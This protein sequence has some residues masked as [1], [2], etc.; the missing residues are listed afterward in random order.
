MVFMLVNLCSGAGRFRFVAIIARV[1][2]DGERSRRLLTITAIF[3]VVILSILVLFLNVH[4]FAAGVA[5]EILIRFG[6]GELPTRDFDSFSTFSYIIA[7]FTTMLLLPI[8]TLL[9]VLIWYSAAPMHRRNIA[10]FGAAM[11]LILRIGL[12][13]MFITETGLNAENHIGARAVFGSVPGLWACGVLSVSAALIS[14]LALRDARPALRFLAIAACLC[15]LVV[16]IWGAFEIMVGLFAID[17]MITAFVFG[18]LLS[19]FNR[20]TSV[21]SNAG[22]TEQLGRLFGA[23]EEVRAQSMDG[24]ERP[25]TIV[26][27]SPPLSKWL[28]AGGFFLLIGVFSVITSNWVFHSFFGFSEDEAWWWLT[29]WGHWLEIRWW[30]SFWA[31]STICVIAFDLV[32]VAFA[33]AQE[34]REQSMDAIERPPTIVAASPSLSKWLV[35]GGFVLIGLAPAIGLKWAFHNLFELRLDGAAGSWVTIWAVAIG[36]GTIVFAAAA[37]YELRD[38]AVQLGIAAFLCAFAIMIFNWGAESDS[39]L[40]AHTNDLSLWLTLPI[41]FLGTLALSATVVLDKQR[42]SWPF[43]AAYL[44]IYILPHAFTGSGYV[45]DLSKLDLFSWIN[46]SVIVF[47]FLFAIPVYFAIDQAQGRTRLAKDNGL[48]G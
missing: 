48:S 31:W 17:Y 26:A 1:I 3:S 16:L 9:M 44:F 6:Y 40:M 42:W 5:K 33:V 37:R 34:L 14:G 29:T 46:M 24:T 45:K 23:A 10:L 27:A 4:E 18:W 7:T 21:R 30:L 19:V 39:K 32:I 22:P 8:T 36:L 15:P 13:F 2:D 20:P 47:V 43:W 25:P 12:T 28:G 11:W 41:V 35:A 38:R